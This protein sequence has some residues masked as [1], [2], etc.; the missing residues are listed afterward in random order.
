MSYPEDV[1]YLVLFSLVLCVA[2]GLADGGK[3]PLSAD[4]AFLREANMMRLKSEGKEACDMTTA[5]KAIAVGE[6]GCCKAPGM[7]K[8]YKVFVAGKGYELFSC[9]EDAGKARKALIAKGKRVGPV[10]K[11]SAK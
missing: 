10:Q 3:K 11:V 5:T 2:S 7:P 9:D 6:K 1:K 8:G 4:E